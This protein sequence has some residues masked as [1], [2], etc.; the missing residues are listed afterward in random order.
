MSYIRLHK[1]ETD[2]RVTVKLFATLVRFKEGS[3][4]ARP[5]DV[6]LPESSTVRDLIDTLKIPPEE[7]HI[8]FINNI[9]EGPDSRLKEN[10]VVGMF[11]P[12]GGG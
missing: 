11:P 1:E 10:D 7:T 3:R 5:F 8:V 12:V 2:M 9:I 4:A 6:E